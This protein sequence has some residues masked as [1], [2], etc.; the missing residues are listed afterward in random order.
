MDPNGLDIARKLVR[1]LK[2]D[3]RIVYLN[4]KRPGEADQRGYIEGWNKFK[5]AWYA[6][7]NSGEGTLVVDT[8][9]EMYEECRLAHFGKVESIRGRYYGPVNAEL[10]VLY[11]DLQTSPLSACIIH[12]MKK[13]WGPNPAGGEDKPTGNLLPSGWSEMEDGYAAQGNVELWRDDTVMAEWVQRGKPDLGWE[14]AKGV[15]KFPFHLYVKEYNLDI[16]MSGTDFTTDIM[17]F[18][19]MIIMATGGLP[20]G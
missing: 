7:I 1:E 13:E 8:G 3:I 19:N 20:G 10:K 18:S 15:W 17:T 6:A 12:K 2:R 5:A 4:H 16:G 11:R 14:D 9:T